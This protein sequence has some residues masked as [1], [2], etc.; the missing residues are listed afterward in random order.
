MNC[1]QVGRLSAQAYATALKRI[2]ASCGSNGNHIATPGRHWDSIDV[3]ELLISSAKRIKRER[4]RLQKRRGLK[5]AFE[6]TRKARQRN[7]TRK[8]D[9]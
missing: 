3:I 1:A 5:G 4:L 2:K 8:L 6:T 9:D 7:K